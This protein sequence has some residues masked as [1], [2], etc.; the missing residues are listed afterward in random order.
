MTDRS[1]KNRPKAA[2]QKTA[3]KRLLKKPPESGCSKNRPKAAAQK[4]AR[5]RLLKKP[6]KALLSD[7]ACSCTQN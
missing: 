1:G 2:A 7:K 6:P 4:T 3:R 5:K